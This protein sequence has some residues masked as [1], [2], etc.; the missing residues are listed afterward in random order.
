IAAAWEA[1]AD[2]VIVYMHWGKENTHTVIR[3]QRTIAQELADAGANLILGSHPHCTQEFDLL[4]T[5]HGNVP[6]IYSLGNFVSS[7]AGRAIN[8][9]GMILKFVIEKD[10]V[11]GETTLQALSYIPTCCSTT[12]EGRFVVLPASEAYIAESPYANALQSSRERTIDV[13]GTDIATP[14]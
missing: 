5:E 11:T 13:L 8:R 1:G 9:D 7:M 14:E 10:N 12:S 2:F 6:V 4:E 3:R